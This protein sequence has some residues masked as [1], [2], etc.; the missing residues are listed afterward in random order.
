MKTR[1][2]VLWGPGQDW[3][4]EE[5]ELDAPGPGEVLVETKVS[6]M[7]HS[8][9]HVVT[10]D[11]MMPHYPFVGGHEGA[12]EVVAVGDGVTTVAP[13]DHV[14][15]S[16]IPSCGRCKWCMSG[17]SNLCDLGA[18][19]FDVGMLRDG[20]MAHHCGDQDLA[21]FSQ[22]GTFAEHMLVDESSVI[23]VEPD[24]PWHAVALVSCGVA[25][26]FGSAMHRADVRPG[27]SVAVIGIGGVGINAVQGAVAAGATRVIAI[28]PVEFKREKAME[29]GATHAYASIDE[30]MAPI[31]EI[32]WGEGCNKVI[33]TP[34]LM[35]GDLIDPA[36]AITAKGG[37]VVVTAVAN[38]LD[39][40]VSMNMFLLSMME[41]EVK[42]CLFGSGN[43]RFD[44][45]NLLMMYREG[46]LKLDELVTRRYSLDEINQGYQDMRDGKNIRGVIDFT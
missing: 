1:A 46:K 18:K 11:M 39:S 22:L 28:D 24:I 4:V 37:T 33:L 31:N 30:A 45:P 12:G 2:A 25:T 15:M 36:L 9:E 7:C 21:R 13:G 41:K 27:D 43:P 6:G 34:G 19:L 40:Q 26:G 8:D 20:R 44:I 14:S 10:G 3:K 29:F 35:K 38:M 23:K 32:T 16:F 5:V 42:G 17:R